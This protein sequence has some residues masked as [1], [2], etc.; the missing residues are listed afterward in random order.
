MGIYDL[1][2]ELVVSTSV[3]PDVILYIWIFLTYVVDVVRG[4]VVGI[5]AFIVFR[6]LYALWLRRKKHSAPGSG[7]ASS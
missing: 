7:A 6:I 4:F 5:S 2:Q 1:L 3:N